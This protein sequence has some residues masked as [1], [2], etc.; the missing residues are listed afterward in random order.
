MSPRRSIWD[1]FGEPPAQP[2]QGRSPF[3]L[4]GDP[5]RRS[6]HPP[7]EHPPGEHPAWPPPPCALHFDPRFVYWAMRN[8][9]VAEAAKNLLILGAVGAG[10]TTAIH[11]F[12]QSLAPRFAAGQSIPE[13]LI[14]FD[15]KRDILP[16]LASYGLGPDQKNVWVLNPFD[17]RCAVW[18]L[19]DAAQSPAS[20]RYVA[21]ALVPEEKESTAPFYATA[22][23]DLLTYVMWGLQ[24]RCGTRWSFRD[25]LCAA[26]S[27]EHIAAITSHHPRGQRLAAA[28]LND[29]RHALGVCSTL[30]TKLGRFEEVA[31]LWHSRPSARVFSVPE[32]LRQPGVL[33]LGWDPVLNESLWPINAIILKCLTDEIL[34]GPRR[35]A[36]R[37]W[38]VFDEFRAMG[39]VEAIHNLV[40][41]GREKGAS[42]L[43]ALQSIEGLLEVYGDHAA[44]D[45]LSACAQKTFLRLGDPDSAAWAERYFGMIRRTEP[46]VSETFGG[47]SGRSTTF[48]YKVEDR[49]SLL[50]S[51]FLNLPFT[52]PGRPYKAVHDVPWLDRTII[53][54]RPFDEI[55]A[56]RP[57]PPQD[58]LAFV[59]RPD[60][61]EETLKE[62]TPAER[63]FFGVKSTVARRPKRKRKR[64][65]SLPTREPVD[66]Q[67]PGRDNHQP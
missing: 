5:A 47:G 10:K 11:L 28:I 36:P 64:R 15:A 2:R 8:M 45:I 51:Y 30:A 16:T 7:G 48:Q 50:A 32:F 57:L 14:V 55:N 39:K 22:A 35:R 53:T 31:G 21:T 27:P 61:E 23:R 54:E 13:Q 20:A 60:K 42:V 65:Q 1:L 33:V 12:L 66:P 67:R 59:P 43:I 49:A 37:H 19:A 52:G 44:K 26:D 17:D 41:R 29:E 9:P 58:A 18:N 62:W 3:D 46:T 38:F 34:R 40:N 56:W 4:F 6:D 25:L 63:K 24:R